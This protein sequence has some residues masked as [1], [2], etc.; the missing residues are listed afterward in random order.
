MFIP[1]VAYVWARLFSPGISKAILGVPNHILAGSQAYRIAGGVF[2][3][4]FLHGTYSPEFAISAA[5]LDTFIG[6]T[7]LPLAFPLLRRPAP[8]L[9]AA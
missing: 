4:A 3:R 2:F 1:V 9:T 5:V 7:A 6:L 8:S